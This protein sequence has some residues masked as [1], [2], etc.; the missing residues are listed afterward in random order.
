MKICLLSYRGNPYCGGQGIYISYLARQLVAMGH[1]VHLV[2]GPPYP[3]EIEGVYLHKISNHNYFNMKKDFIDPE[4]PFSTLKPLNFYEFLSS[5]FGVFP[6]METFSIRA[7]R[8]IQR[9][10]SKYRFD[11][12]HDNQCL[13]YGYLLLKN[14]GVPIIS[15]I[16]HPL[17]IDRE[18]WFEF[19][20]GFMQKMRRMLY[21]PLIMQKYVAH[22]MERI[23]TVS[24]DSAR[25]ITEA[26]GI[27][28][29]KIIVVYNGMDT[30]LFYPE[31]NVKK[32]KN[33]LI[34]VGN[35]E[36]R[37]KGVAY[38]LK[39]LSMMKQRAH[40]TIVDGGAPNRS[41]IPSLIDRLGMNHRVTFTGKIPIERLNRLYSETEIA[42]APSLYEGF[43]FPAAE[44]MACQLPVIAAESGAL[45]EVVGEHMKTGY[46]VPPRNSEALARG[47]DFLLDNPPV[48]KKLGINGKK[49][50]EREF[51]WEK[52]AEDMVRIYRETTDAHR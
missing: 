15:T 49:R 23:V 48:M 35:I 44:A 4:D 40:L 50:V 26:F 22:R 13:G 12:I 9:L 6:E 19:P 5:R 3:H 2:V 52:A 31:K 39:A 11:I 37:K 47:L 17:T 51:R 34:F 20:S 42:I 16:H 43:G 30:G 32:K 27:P 41:I 25:M 46:L 18:I 21:Y 29:E 24:K 14:C 8:L 1:E 28:E 38:L 7:A 36:D 33:S 45:P 10:N